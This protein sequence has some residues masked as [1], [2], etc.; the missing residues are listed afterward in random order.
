LLVIGFGVGWVFQVLGLIMRTPN[1]VM[2]LAFTGIMPLVFA[3]NIMVDPGTMP[4]WLQAFVDVNPVS[5][6][7]TAMRGLMKGSA[8]WT[9]I[10]LALLT[11][12]LLTATLAPLTLWLYRRR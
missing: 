9:E 11:P 12:A 7:T 4:Q 10:G 2:T 8:T 1:T 5:L 3:S 6:M